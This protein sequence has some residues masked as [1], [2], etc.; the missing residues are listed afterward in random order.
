MDPSYIKY[1]SGHNLNNL[2]STRKQ[3]FGSARKYAIWMGNF[4]F[5]SCGF[6]VGDLFHSG[7]TLLESEN[8]NRK[9]SYWNN[10]E[11]YQ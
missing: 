3:K 6:V 7:S 1:F 10:L 8:I 2:L 9:K 4:Y 11:V 5:N